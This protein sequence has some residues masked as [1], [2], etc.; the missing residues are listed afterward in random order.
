MA[1]ACV[2][3]CGLLFFST[4]G[5]SAQDFGFGA[6]DTTT[7]GATATAIVSSDNGKP[8]VAVGGSLAFSLLGFPV[9]LFDGDFSHSTALPEA[10]LSISASGSK[11]DAKISLRLNKDILENRPGSL[12][13]EARLRV[14]WGQKTTVES[15]LMRVSWGRAD[16]LSVLDVINPRDLSNL[17]L[18]DEN[19]RKIAVPMLRLK[20]ALGEH[21]SAE[22]I[23][24]PWF[25]GD[26][27]AI[28]GPW[29][30]PNWPPH[31]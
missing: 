7:D 19:D 15:G 9:A 17:T 12:L 27:I 22:L 6:A 5:V 8:A 29:V 2:L 26:R 31:R 10:L 3:A 18:R 20:Q 13:D 16:S 14:F 25:E 30:P 1:L 4:S 24:L 23:Y 21:A 28:S 11:V